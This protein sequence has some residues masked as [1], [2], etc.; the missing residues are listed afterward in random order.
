MKYVLT[1]RSRVNFVAH[2]PLHKFKGWAEEGLSGGL[3]ID[4]EHG[5]V[6][7]LHAEVETRCFQT[8]DQERTRAMSQFF[9]LSEHPYATF[10][11]GQQI[12]LRPAGKDCWSTKMPGILSFVDIHRLLPVIGKL[13]LENER[14]IWELQCKWSFKAYGLK[15][16]RLL[17]LTVRDIVDIS[18]RLE[19]IYQEEKDQ[20]NVHQ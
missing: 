12:S 19:F 11:I 4:L 18:A 6:S 10:K 1:D 16:P 2:A 13:R 9:N 7:S 8:P 15:A 20:E 5:M 3:D 17:M 14:L